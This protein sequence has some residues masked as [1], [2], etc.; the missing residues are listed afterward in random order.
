MTILLW[1][2]MGAS[3]L[4]AFGQVAHPVAEKLFE[5]CTEEDCSRGAHGLHLF[6]LCSLGISF[7]CL[8]VQSFINARKPPPPDATVAEISDA[9]SNG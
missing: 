9:K 1:F 6:V 4:I 5:T 3:V 8:L 7:V 2:V